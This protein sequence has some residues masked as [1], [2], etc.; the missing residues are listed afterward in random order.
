MCCKWK[1]NC[2]F[3]FGSFHAKIEINV[4]RCASRVQVTCKY[5]I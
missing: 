5:Y 3:F 1:D 4:A 2:L